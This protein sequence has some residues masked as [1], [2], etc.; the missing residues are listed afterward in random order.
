VKFCIADLHIMLTN[1]K[2]VSRKTKKYDPC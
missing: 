2:P 1:I